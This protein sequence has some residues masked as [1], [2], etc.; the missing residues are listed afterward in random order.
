MGLNRVV[1]TLACAAA[2]SGRSPARAA[3]PSTIA[4]ASGGE[5][6]LDNATV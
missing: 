2:L 1:L 3:E 5:R 6:K 4:A